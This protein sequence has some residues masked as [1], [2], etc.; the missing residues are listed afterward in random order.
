MGTVALQPTLQLSATYCTTLQLHCGTLQHTH[1]SNAQRRVPNSLQDPYRE[2]NRVQ[3]LHSRAPV[4]WAAVCCS[5][6]QC[7]AVCC[8]VLQ[9]VAVCNREQLLHSRAPVERAMLHS[10]VQYGVATISRLL[11]ITGLFCKRAL[12]KRLYPAKETDNLKEPTT[13]SHVIVSEAPVLSFGMDKVTRVAVFCVVL[14][15]VAV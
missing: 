15:C 11:K 6:L 8:S 10:K 2:C 14:Q 9:Y 3:S 5:V 7:V 1:T 12:Q 4:Q 13:L